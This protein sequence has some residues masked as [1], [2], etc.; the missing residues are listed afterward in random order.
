MTPRAPR[1]AAPHDREP[2]GIDQIP[3]WTGVSV[4]APRAFRDG[5]AHL[6]NDLNDEQYAAVT[7]GEGPLLVVAGAGTGKTQVITRRV[8]WLIA[9]QRALPEEILALTF[10]DRAAEE[11]QDAS[12]AS[13]RMGTPPRRSRPSTLGAT[14]CCVKTH[15]VSAS[16]VNCASLGGPKLFSSYASISLNLDS[17]DLPRSATQRAFLATLQATSHA[18]RRRRSVPMRLKPLQPNCARRLPPL[19]L[20]LRHQQR[21]GRSWTSMLLH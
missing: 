14:S 15:T 2:A 16:L 9:E 8:A 3:V 1:S 11:M 19:F 6:L 7:Y 12:T 5:L 18:Q 17:H 4:R 13:C 20:M 10:T 21:N